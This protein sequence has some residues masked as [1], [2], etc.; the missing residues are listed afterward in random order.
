M[1]SAKV[2]NQVQLLCKHVRNSSSTFGNIQVV[3]VG[4][5]FQLPPVSNELLGDRGNFYFALPWFEHFFPHKLNLHVI[6][7]QDDPIVI[8]CTNELE[9][10]NPSDGTVLFL[11]SL[12]RPIQDEETSIHLFARNLEVDLFNYN[13]VQT[14][15]GMLKVYTAVD[16]GAHPYLNKFLAPKKLGLK[17][18]CRVMLVKNVNDVLVNDLRGTVVELNNESVDIEFVLEKKHITCNISAT[19]FTIFDPVDKAVVAKRVQLP[20]KL[21]Y[22]IT[23]HKSQGLEKV[24]V[25]CE[26]CFQPGQLGVAVGRAMSVDGLKVVNFTKYL[27]KKHPANV[28]KFYDSI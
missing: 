8:K 6:H 4:D 10:G 24:T 18:G 19:I 25:N 27:W 20:L 15:D 28:F 5:F 23:I 12:D 13:K 22:G 17:V 3:I 11:N 26:H 2:L 1:I 14:I 16:E 9:K 7:R 21:A